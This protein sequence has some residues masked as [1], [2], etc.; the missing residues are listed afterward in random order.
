MDKN[1]ST[2]INNAQDLIKKY[3]DIGLKSLDSIHLI[4]NFI[5]NSQL[6]PIFNFALNKS[7]PIFYFPL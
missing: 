2:I 4:K 3:G 6:L 7:P 1:N 5:P